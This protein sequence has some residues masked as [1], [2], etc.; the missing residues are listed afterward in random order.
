MGFGTVAFFLIVA[1]F[2]VVGR[3][4]P[5]RFRL[6]VWMLIVAGGVVPWASWTDHAHLDRIEWLPFTRDVRFRDIWLNVL[7][8]VPVG[9]FY[10]AADARGPRSRGLLGAAVCGLTLSVVTET[11]QIFSHGRFPAMTDVLT[12]TTGAF[13]GAWLARAW[14]R[15]K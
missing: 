15:K 4:V 13:L 8:Y 5:P 9:S 12:N 3:V 1:S 14:R 7:F 11:T 10:S 6:L 2:A